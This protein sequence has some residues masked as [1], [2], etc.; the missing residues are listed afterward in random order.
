MIGRTK[1]LPMLSQESCSG[2][3]ISMSKAGRQS[4]H[5]FRGHFS[6]RVEDASASRIELSNLLMLIVSKMSSRDPLQISS[7]ST[8]Y[9]CEG[10]SA[11]DLN[12]N[13]RF[14]RSTILIRSNPHQVDK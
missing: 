12:A 11:R 1:P 13:H 2:S 5:Y 10:L 14:A 9:C 4:N 7:F 3:S 6:V 8:L